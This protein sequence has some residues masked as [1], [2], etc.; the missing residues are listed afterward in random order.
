MAEAERKR[1]ENVDIDLKAKE[2]LE[3]REIRPDRC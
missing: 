3:D 2:N 1:R